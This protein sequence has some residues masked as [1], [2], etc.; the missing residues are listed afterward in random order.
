MV[1]EKILLVTNYFP[2]EK[3]AAANRMFSL[4]TALAENKYQVAVVCPFPNYPKGKVFDNYKGKL[5]DKSIESELTVHRLWVWPSNSQNKFLRLL[6]MISFSI[7]LMLFFFFKKIPKKV[8][9]QYSPVFVGF[10]A[11]F[12][13]W[14]FRK[15]LILNISDLWP[16]AGLEMGLLKKG[17]YYSI[18]KKIELFC[19][20]KATLITGQ[21]KEILTHI[22]NLGFKKESFLYRNLPRFKAPAISEKLP[23]PKISLVYGGLL[24]LAQGLFKICSQIEFPENVT[25]HIYG[26]GPEKD[27]I[28]S[29]NNNQILFHD[30]IAREKL[31]EELLQYDIAFIPLTNRI[32][33]SVPSKIFEYSRLGLPILYYGGGE[34]EQ[35]VAKNNL[36]WVIPVNNLK[37]LQEFINSLNTDKLREFSRA[38]VQK[39]A[40]EAFNFEKQFES[41]I[42]RIEFL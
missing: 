18:L 8:F 5:Y 16:L 25:I 32:Y 6:S 42:K 33:G 14:V 12:W 30:E 34:G 24:G 19:Y 2:P 21:S 4:A 40:L 37:E 23:E 22:K 3:G 31:H 39:N 29:L 7:S 26:A 10:T 20:G 35:I 15:K 9:I 1:T 41:F 38:R 17:I 13:G 11:V 36:G 27:A 28:M